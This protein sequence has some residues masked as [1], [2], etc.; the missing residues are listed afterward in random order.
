MTHDRT[1]AETAF[2]TS[3]HNR[4]AK[5][6]G[7]DHP[8]RARKIVLPNITPSFRISR[9]MS[10]FTIGSCFARHIELH[11][12]EA[13][14]VVPAFD[15][16]VPA[17]ELWGNTRM[18]AGFLNKYTPHSMLN[19]VEFAFGDS[20]GQEYLVEMPGGW[21]DTQCHT[22]TPVTL[23]RGLARRQEIRRLYRDAIR[24]S[25][26]VIITLGLVEAW[27]DAQNGVYLNETPLPAMLKQHPGRFQF[28]VLSPTDTI[29][30][31]NRLIELIR[32]NGP[33]DQKIMVTVSPIPLQRTFTGQDV[34]V[35]NSYSKSLLRVAAE[36]A[37]NR[38]PGLDYYP[39]FES[40]GISDQFETWEDDMVHVR[41]RAVKA[42]VTR[43]LRDYGADT[44]GADTQEPAPQGATAG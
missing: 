25:Q 18:Q 13:G 22:D 3:R 14:Y 8:A 39:S 31:V 11:L 35:A 4:S 9:G 38:F 7:R 26:L 37:V 16:A 5:W 24:N 34:L 1:S 41:L 36:V 32:A 33:A 28:E 44:Q 23:E 27:W 12:K 30:C 2:R 40:V 20:S 21:L 19:E 42:N 10:V 29:A 15:Y 17:Q 43:M 6:P